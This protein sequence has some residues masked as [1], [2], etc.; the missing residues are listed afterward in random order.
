MKKEKIADF[1]RR[2]S[3]CNRSGL[4]VVIYDIYFAYM[5]DVRKAFQDSDWDGYKESVRHAQRAIDELTD[6]LDF[7]YDMAGNLYRIY[8]FCKDLLAKAIYKRD[9]RE[10]ETAERL[11]RKLYQSFVEVAK[12]DTSKPLM[13][14]AQQVYA[15]FTYGRDDLTETCQNV[16]NNR[17]FL[18]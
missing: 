7:S 4:I 17:G 10:A 15:G 8:V 18:A 13:Q 11:M 5:E 12:Q 6:V 16:V 9:L 14:N 1:T 2:I 3:Q